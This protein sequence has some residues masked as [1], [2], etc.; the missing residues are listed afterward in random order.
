MSRVPLTV[1][2]NLRVYDRV[3]PLYDAVIGPVSRR[4]RDRAVA[5]LR[6]APDETLLLVGV[7]SGLDL[8][9]LPRGVRGLG[10]DLSDGMLQRAR[11]RKEQ[12]GMPNFELR[13]MDAQ[14]LA[15]P[16][17]SFDAVY[18]PL[19]VTVAPD[20]PRVLAEA[21]RVAKPG[22][23]LVVV[24][25]FWPEERPRSAPVRLASRFLGA[26]ATHV[27]RRFSEIHAGAPHLEVVGDEHLALGGFFRLVTLRKPG[28]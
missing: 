8:P 10:V 3:G 19:I 18:L 2:S 27:D 23:R 6:L 13:E 26:L 7:G 12:L 20:G 16:D 9:H 17:A 24:D 25:K 1:Q 11:A 21:A 14:D 28:S 4:A 22:A 15:L 5:S